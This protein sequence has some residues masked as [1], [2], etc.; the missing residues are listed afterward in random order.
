[1]LPYCLKGTLGLR[2]ESGALLTCMLVQPE[3]R[4]VVLSTTF[5]LLLILRRW[6]LELR[7]GLT[8]FFALRVSNLFDIKEFDNVLVLIDIKY[9]HT[10]NSNWRFW[11]Y[12]L[13]FY[14]TFLLFQ[15]C[16]LLSFNFKRN[17]YDNLF[18]S[19]FNLFFD[20]F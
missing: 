12:V 20:T 10:L 14:F 9:L 5:L 3:T 1:M 11:Y 6:H 18:C 19:R 7:N 13:I 15:H 17:I 2:V 16:L 8:L 4:I